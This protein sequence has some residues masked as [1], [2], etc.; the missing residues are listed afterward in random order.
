VVDVRSFFFRV[1]RNEAVTYRRKLAR[2]RLSEV[3][4]A[5]T[6]G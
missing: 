2:Q 5:R 3:G 1:A 4:V 6:S